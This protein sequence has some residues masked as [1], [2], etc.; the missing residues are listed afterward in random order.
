MAEA[1]SQFADGVQERIMEEYGDLRQS[2]DSAILAARGIRQLTS[3]EKEFYQ[4]WLM[5]Q[6]LRTRSRHWWISQR[7]CRRR[8][9]TP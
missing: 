8:L 5:P 3:E 2:R 7:Q 1:F 4:A 9:L 6:N